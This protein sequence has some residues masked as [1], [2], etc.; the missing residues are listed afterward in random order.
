MGDD[1]AIIVGIDSY[2]KTQNDKAFSPL[3]S[4]VKDATE[5]KK[6]LI[7]PTGGAMEE[8]PSRIFT[9]NSPPVLNDQLPLPTDARPIKDQIDD[10]L[11]AMGFGDGRRIGDRLYFYFSGH[12]IGLG[13]SEVA[14]MMANALRTMENRNIGLRQYRE[15]MQERHLF[16]E[17]IFIADCCRTR[18]TKPIEPGGPVFTDPKAPHMPPVRDVAILAAEYGELSFAVS[19]GKGLL[20]QALLEGL[21]GSPE[22]VDQK[23][24]VTS[25]TLKNFLPERVRKLAKDN[26]VMQSPELNLFPEKTEI[27][28]CKPKKTVKVKIIAAAGLAG[29]IIVCDGEKNELSRREAALATNDSPWEV[30]LFDSASPYL[31][32][33]TGP[34]RTLMFTLSEVKENNNVFQVA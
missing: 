11:A 34:N 6:W 9:I 28:F 18:E 33:V 26:L 12:G 17:V 4:A 27:V 22:A 14:L 7:S 23:G 30:E 31:V 20:T 5:F 3:T 1:Y 19:G 25:N 10:A 21:N 2:A 24:R 29:D 13:S 32:K 15:Y 16:D 8:S